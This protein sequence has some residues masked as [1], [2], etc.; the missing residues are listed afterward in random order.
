MI[1]TK[2]VVL[3]KSTSVFEPIDWCMEVIG[4][5]S[6]NGFNGSAVGSLDGSIDDVAWM[7]DGFMGDTEVNSIGKIIGEL[8]G[9]PVAAAVNATDGTVADVR[10]SLGTIVESS[11]QIVLDVVDITIGSI[12]IIF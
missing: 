1:I 2:Y 8:E 5:M 10:L 6:A 11:L 9:T 7:I 4:A 12:V 3:I